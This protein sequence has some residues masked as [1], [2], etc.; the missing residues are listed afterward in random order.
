M[1]LIFRLVRAV[2]VGGIRHPPP[3]RLA[4]VAILGLIREPTLGL[5]RQVTSDVGTSVGHPQGLDAGRTDDDSALHAVSRR[6]AE[7]RRVGTLRADDDVDL[8]APREAQDRSHGRDRRRNSLPRLASRLARL[9]IDG[10][11]H[12]VHSCDIFLVFVNDDDEGRKLRQG[13][14]SVI[15][16]LGPRVHFGL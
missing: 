15:D 12:I 4:D 5:D 2:H 10:A 16:R 8:Q 3:L 7:P 1:A 13:L 14:R 11:P 6:A 9:R